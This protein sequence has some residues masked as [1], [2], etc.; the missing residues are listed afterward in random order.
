MRFQFLELVCA[1]LIFVSGC[2]SASVSYRNL[3]SGPKSDNEFWKQP[4]VGCVEE[5]YPKLIDAEKC[6]DQS[7]LDEVTKAACKLRNDVADEIAHPGVQVP[8]WTWLT[9]HEYI[10]RDEKIKIIYD[11]AEKYGM[12]PQFLYGVVNL[13]AMLTDQGVIRDGGNYSC[14]TG[15]LN[16]AQY[17]AWISA[18]PAEVQAR[19]EWPTGILCDEN[20]LPAEIVGTVF[21]SM[22]F[23]KSVTK[24]SNE[25]YDDWQIEMHAAEADAVSE[26]TVRK[27]LDAF[28]TSQ[29]LDP[30][31]R[32]YAAIRSYTRH[33]S[34]PHNAIPGIAHTL[35]NLFEKH[36]PKKLRKQEI[37]SG[38][39]SFNRSC[40]RPY[41]SKF[42][43]VHAGWLLAYGAHNRGEEVA[44]DLTHV[45]AIRKSR[46]RKPIDPLEIL[47]LVSESQN[48]GAENM[49]HVLVR[50][51]PDGKIPTN[52][53]SNSPE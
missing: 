23:T 7:T 30:D 52:L 39:E 21:E 24:V 44:D 12:S 40:A 5:L 46:K 49:K 10:D 4:P 51:F 29:G 13:E 33:C 27:N 20:T 47:N 45:R 14:G 53:K 19:L 22:D 18:E 2:S 16:I 43:P 15:S 36:V 11:A 37:Y 34:D 6:T 9:L 31:E 28:L 25:G 26:G 1:T 8:N 35:R 42:Y 3:A 17:C 48:G 32:Q 41:L 38:K 50:M